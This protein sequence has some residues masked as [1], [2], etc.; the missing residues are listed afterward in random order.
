VTPTGKPPPGEQASVGTKPSGK[1]GK[2]VSPGH[3]GSVVAKVQRPVETIDDD[4]R[5]AQ[6]WLAAG[7]QANRPDI[8]AAANTLLTKLQGDKINEDYRT[9]QLGQSNER[10]AATVAAHNETARH[11]RWNEAHP[12]PVGVGTTVFAPGVKTVTGADAYQQLSGPA[13][14]LIQKWKAAGVTPDQAQAL[15]AKTMTGNDKIYAALYVSS[16]DYKGNKVT[17]PADKLKQNS[18]WGVVNSRE[19]EMISDGVNAYGSVQKFV[20]FLKTPQ[21][22]SIMGQLDDAGKA[23]LGIQ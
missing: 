16:P 6:A 20:D 5:Q 1:P 18:L 3:F 11:N 9:A 22:A 19:Q 12:R 8:I 15:I 2:M 21:G 14:Q 17:Q 10:I 7:A 4:I 13:Q 23:V